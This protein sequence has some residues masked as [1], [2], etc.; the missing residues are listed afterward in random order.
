VFRNN[1]SRLSL[2]VHGNDHTKAELARNYTPPARASLLRQ[3][4]H[5]IERLE[6]AAGLRVS[7]VMV[8]PHGACSEAMLEELPGCG[9]EAA[10]ISHGSLR[11]HNKGKT[12]TRK[13]GYAVSELIAGCP[14]LPRWGLAGNARNT[15]LL[16][17]FLNQPIILRGHHRDL[18]D[19]TEVLDELARF[20]NSLGTVTW[21]N[22]TELSRLNYLRRLDGNTL[23]LKL[24]GR[25]M[26]VQ[27]PE[28]ATRLVIEKAADQVREGWQITG[29][30]GAVWKVKAGDSVPLPET[31]SGA[32]AI[33]TIS[34][35]ETSVQNK[36]GRTSGRAILRRLLTEAR[37]R[38]LSAA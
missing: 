38:L 13:V 37:D 26:K 35:S 8:P 36:R 15:I 7:R 10:C 32:I 31:L 5:R 30:D 34:E 28:G 16:A 21:S 1:A 18:R 11:A 9:F 2:L 22:L 14:V 33:Q 25:T 4:V 6:R 27:L 23:R 19:G 29:A 3:A 20:I 24:L 17:A 12:W